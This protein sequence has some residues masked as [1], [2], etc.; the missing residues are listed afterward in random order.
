MVGDKTRL[1]KKHKI[2]A[3][4]QPCKK[5]KGG[6]FL[7]SAH[8]GPSSLLLWMGPWCL[9]LQTMRWAKWC[10]RGRTMQLKK[11]CKVWEG[12]QFLPKVHS[13]SSS[14]SL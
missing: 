14:S 2:S 7:P 9:G 3:V 12:G 11:S 1:L 6:Q 4:E 13:F 8:G 5:W 10:G